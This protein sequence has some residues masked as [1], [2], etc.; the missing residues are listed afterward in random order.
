MLHA[1]LSAREMCRLKVLYA[2]YNRAQTG[3]LPIRIQVMNFAGS[4]FGA[5]VGSDKLHIL[6][7]TFGFIFASITDKFYNTN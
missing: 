6:H 2:K 7:R 4:A 3:T 1:R 5:S